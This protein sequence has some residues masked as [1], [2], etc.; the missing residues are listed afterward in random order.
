MFKSLLPLNMFI[1]RAL[2]IKF[3]YLL[4]VFF[5]IFLTTNAE[6]SKK[7]ARP[8]KQIGDV[9]QVGLPV[10]AGSMTL[11]YRDFEGTL[12]F[13]KSFGTTLGV[14][15]ILKPII[16]EERPISSSN[17]K[18]GRSAGNM[19]F[20]SGHTAAAFGGAAFLQMRYGWWFGAPSYLAA[21]YVGFSRVYGQ[22]HWF[23]DVLGGAAIAIGANV[24]FTTRYCGKK[25]QVDP[26]LEEDR[27]GISLHWDL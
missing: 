20:P 3:K 13:A 15:Y 2:V 17:L 23:R 4:I 6:A 9:I 18:Q 25:V 1:K 27:K 14:T 19:S 5:C 26:I 21:S 12:E 22:K 7:G 24:L 10:L 8:V 16:N 11:A